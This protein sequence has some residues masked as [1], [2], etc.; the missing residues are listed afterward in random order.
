MFSVYTE[1]TLKPTFEVVSVYIRFE[2]LFKPQLTSIDS[3]FWDASKEYDK[4]GRRRKS[5]DQ[6]G[7][8]KIF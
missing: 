7:G 4:K 3:P 6:E 8:E 1:T 2:K 5:S